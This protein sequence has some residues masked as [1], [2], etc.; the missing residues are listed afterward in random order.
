MLDRIH[1][2]ISARISVLWIASTEEE[3]V[4]RAL[5]GL[6]TTTSPQAI[7]ANYSLI[8]NEGNPGFF[9]DGQDLPQ[10]ISKPMSPLKAIISCCNLARLQQDTPHFFVILDAHTHMKNEAIR[11][12]IIDASRKL[13]GTS[14]TLFLLSHER[15]I[16]HDIRDSVTLVKPDL[17]TE[18]MLS[19]LALSIGS[20]FDVEIDEKKCAYALKGLGLAQARDLMLQD[21][22]NNNGTISASRLMALKADML[23]NVPGI[24]YQQDCSPMKEVGGFEHFKSWLTLRKTGFSEEAKKFGLPTPRGILISGVPGCGKSLLAEAIASELQLPLIIF[25]LHACEGSLVG[26]THEK[27]QT[28][29]MA[30]NACSPCVVLIDEA[31]KF[32]GEGAQRDSGSKQTILAVTL[33]WLQTRKQPAFICMTANKTSNMPPELTRIGD[34]IDQAFFVGLPTQKGREEILRIHINKLGK[35]VDD[36]SL[37]WL[38]KKSRNYTGSELK[39]A[40]IDACWLAFGRHKDGGKSDLIPKDLETA[41][42]DITPMST[43]HSGLINELYHEAVTLGQAKLAS[44]PEETFEPEPKTP[45]ISIIKSGSL[46]ES[47]EGF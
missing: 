4:L 32:F 13:K 11:R 23:S 12:A 42:A 41:I 14:S 45:A 43:R 38:A 21:Y 34:R 16:H 31:E 3:R 44:W 27:I 18:K 22:A 1:S 24:T 19:A 17:P 5:K 20:Q 37:S 33:S 9:A 8:G 15:E 7:I 2:L 25:N 26:E 36:K 29:I 46:K 35:K 28:A 39:Q 6:S 47:C 40:C 30:I 10:E